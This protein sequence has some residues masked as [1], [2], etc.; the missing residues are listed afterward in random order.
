MNRA[1]HF[2]LYFF[3]LF[4]IGLNN[5]GLSMKL[6]SIVLGCTINTAELG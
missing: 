6:V 2:P 4:G 1:E 5:F 3:F